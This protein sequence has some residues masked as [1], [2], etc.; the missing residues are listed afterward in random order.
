[1]EL[2][3]KK[4]RIHQTGEIDLLDLMR[5]WNDGR[6][7][8]WVEFPNG[9]GYDDAQMRKWLQKTN[10]LPG[11][12]HFVVTAEGIGF[13]G[14]VYYAVDRE[15]ARAALDI[16]FVPEAQGRGLATDALRTLINH[17]FETEPDVDAVWTEP[18]EENLAARRLYAR[19]LLK[20][21]PRPSELGEGSYWACTREEWQSE[22]S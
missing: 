16:K 14:E 20:P 19:C 8:R 5:L 22:N 4:V 2:A 6:V 17:V 7:M 12:H 9:L 21:Q 11:C 10:E 13:C 3:G 15:H 1:M 18:S